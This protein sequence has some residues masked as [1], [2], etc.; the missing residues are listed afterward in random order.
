MER[1]PDEIRWDRLSLNPNAID[2]LERHPDEICWDRL[3][4]NPNALHLVYSEYVSF[5]NT[6]I[7]HV[8]NWD[9]LSKNPSIFEYDY[10]KMLETTNIFKEELIAYVFHPRRF[11]MYLMEYNF[12]MND[13]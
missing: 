8:M 10:K 3:S 6:I 7:S 12:D 13:L 1:H 4:L 11:E 2:L 5:H 9:I